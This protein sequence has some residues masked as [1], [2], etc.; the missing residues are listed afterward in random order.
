M[1]AISI[2]ET[3]G[4]ARSTARRIYSRQSNDCQ[5]VSK[6]LLGTQTVLDYLVIVEDPTFDKPPA[7]YLS[8]WII[9]H[10]GGL[11]LWIEPYPGQT[12]WQ[13]RNTSDRPWQLLKLRT[14]FLRVMVGGFPELDRSTSLWWCLARELVTFVYFI[15]YIYSYVSMIYLYNLFTFI[16]TWAL[17]KQQ[18]S[19]R[20]GAM[21]RIRLWAPKRSPTQLAFCGPPLVVASPESPKPRRATRKALAASCHW[22]IWLFPWMSFHPQSLRLFEITTE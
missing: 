20:F 13:H 14:D 2:N 3:T 21:L 7:V 17:Y 1:I 4:L 6:T 15:L 11:L 19:V 5:A 22:S 12:R 9:P 16:Y 10:I 8:W 18:K